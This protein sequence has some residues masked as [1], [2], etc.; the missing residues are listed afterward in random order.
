VPCSDRR[1]RENCAR[2]GEFVRIAPKEGITVQGTFMGEVGMI[3]FVKQWVINIVALVL[4]IVMFEMLLPTGK[5]KKYINLVTGTILIIAIISPLTGFLG[6][7]ADITAL[8]VSNS[9]NLDKLQM[10]NESKVLEKEQMKQIVDVY[11][12]KIIEELEQNAEEVKGVKQAYADVIFNEDYNSP[13]FGEIKRAYIEIVPEATSTKVKKGDTYLKAAAADTTTEKGI[14]IEGV[15]EGS[16]VKPVG[17]IRKVNV[18]K[19]ADTPEMIEKCDPAIKK[20]LE[21]RI[22]DVFGINSDNIVISQINN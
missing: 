11:R 19:T 1:I 14:T 3:E 5:M 15:D 6:K 4:F 8:Q 17:Q 21:D 10:E 22:S 18:G 13:N 12:D 7:N 2:I 20:K 16:S 9:N